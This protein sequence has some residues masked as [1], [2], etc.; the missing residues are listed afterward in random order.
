MSAGGNIV[1]LLCQACALAYVSAFQVGLN[2]NDNPEVSESCSKTRYL[3]IRLNSA[4]AAE[5]VTVKQR[6]WD[7][8]DAEAAY[9]VGMDMAR[10]FRSTVVFFEGMVETCASFQV[11]H[12]LL[13]NRTRL[14]EIVC[15]SETSVTSK[16][17]EMSS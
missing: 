14:F 12:E 13:E 8:R 3:F 7:K 9:R 6:P 1:I 5:L 2:K 17:A 10:I 11:G 16:N 15:R 4:S